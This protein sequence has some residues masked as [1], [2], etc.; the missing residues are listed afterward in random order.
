MLKEISSVERVGLRSH[1]LLINTADQRYYI[2]FKND[3]EL[4]GWKDDLYARISQDVSNPMNFIHRIHVGY[5]P[6]YSVFTVR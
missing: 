6:F 5:D 4:Y 3:E 2:S 1:C